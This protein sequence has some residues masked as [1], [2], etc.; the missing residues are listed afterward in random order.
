MLLIVCEACE[1]EYRIKH[2]MNERYYMIEYCTFCGDEL[3][4]ELE[5]DI[6]FY[7]DYDE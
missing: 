6:D 4:K 2:D 3:T 1:A 7:E 5:D